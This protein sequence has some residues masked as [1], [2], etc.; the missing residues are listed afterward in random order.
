MRRALHTAVGAWSWC[1]VVIVVG[2]FFLPSVAFANGGAVIYVDRSAPEDGDGQSWQ[3]AFGR[4]QDA[5]SASQSGDQVWVAHGLYSGTVDLRDGVGVYGGFSGNET[6]VEQADPVANPTVFKARPSTPLPGPPCT[7][8]PALSCSG[9][10]A[11]VVTAV[12][13]DAVLDGFT[14]TGGC[15][16]D[17]FEGG[18]GLRIESSTLVVRRC[19]IVRNLTQI[20]WPSEPI[21]GGGIWIG[22]STVLFE[23]C[24]VSANASSDGTDSGSNGGGAYVSNSDA[25]FVDCTFCRNRTGDGASFAEV[26]GDGGWGG[27]IYAFGSTLKIDRCVFR[28]N[29]TGR[30]ASGTQVAPGGDGGHGGAIRTTL[31]QIDIRNSWFIGNMTGNAG[32]GGECC[33]VGGD[34][35]RGSAVSGGSGQIVNSTFVDNVSGRDYPSLT[36]STYGAMSTGAAV[37]NCIVWDN[38]PAVGGDFSATYSCIQGGAPGEGNLDDDPLLLDDRLAPFLFSPCIDAGNPNT[39]V[40]AGELDLLGNPRVVCGRIDIGAIE[41]QTPQDPGDN[42]C[43]ADVDL[44]DIDA[45]IDCVTGPEAGPF[46]PGC[47]V[48]DFDDDGDIDFADFGALQAIVGAGQR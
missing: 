48:F 16:E 38:T 1:Y 23:S 29:R 43:D 46:L 24:E 7:Q 35:G 28:N 25:T 47:Q 12:G 41:F 20:D 11:H 37:T 2:M 36:P 13:V 21:P 9:G 31:G 32:S 40:S 8:Q 42:D 45:I 10:I 5:L 27:A 34:G 15:A 30:G 22:E 3:T 33:G 14:I 4:V 17:D 18:A 26:H 44:F 39:N 19:R 6:S